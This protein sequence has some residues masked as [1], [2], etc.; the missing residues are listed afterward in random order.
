MSELTCP[1]CDEPARFRVPQR[2]A[3]EFRCSDEYRCGPWAGYVYVHA[4][5][6][7]QAVRLAYPMEAS[8]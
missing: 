3:G 2:F 8:P 1:G 6:R 5:D 7:E 4:I